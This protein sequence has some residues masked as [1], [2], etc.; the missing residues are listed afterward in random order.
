MTPAK[1]RRK[2]RWG[3]PLAIVMI[4]VAGVLGVVL[5]A[6]GGG[7]HESSSQGGLAASGVGFALRHPADWHRAKSAPRIPGLPALGQGSVYLTADNNRA[8]FFAARHPGDLSRA[9]PGDLA[10]RLGS[11]GVDR[12][13]ARLRTGVQAYRWTAAPVNGTRVELFAVPLSGA[14]ILAGCAA[15][16][17]ARLDECRQIVA[18]LETEDSPIVEL[19]PDA[20]FA[21]TLRQTIGDAGRAQRNGLKRLRAAHSARGQANAAMG[22]W[23]TLR[24]AGTTLAASK[25]NQPAIGWHRQASDAL[26]SVG[27]G[28]VALA[29]AYRASD[30]AAVAS[31]RQTIRTSEHQFAGALTALAAVGFIDAAQL[32]AER[33]Q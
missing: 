16:R 17:G 21:A 1:R 33:E 3:V 24:T 20:A 27:K 23:R 11:V 2:R 5:G 19:Q 10:A 12:S 9:I 28:Y 13:R 25:P 22:V 7:A 30:R 18:G 15:R 6:S 8:G 29:K 14:T 26:T 32:A 31:A 4:V